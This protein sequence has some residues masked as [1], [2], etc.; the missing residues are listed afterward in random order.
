L[1]IRQDVTGS[2]RE[3]PSVLFTRYYRWSCNML[4]RVEKARER[5]EVHIT[6]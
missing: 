3:L 5:R 4:R 1:A 6:F 2:Y